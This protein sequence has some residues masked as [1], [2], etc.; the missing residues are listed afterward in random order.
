MVLAHDIRLGAVLTHTDRGICRS[1]AANTLCSILVGTLARLAGD[2]SGRAVALGIRDKWSLAS[3]ARG[4]AT[5]RKLSGWAW[6]TLCLVKST[7]LSCVA[8]QAE[9]TLVVR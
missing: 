7:S 4:H 2:A 5:A 3:L 1:T 6:G 9:K 8:W